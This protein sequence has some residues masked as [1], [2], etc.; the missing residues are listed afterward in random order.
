MKT[1]A[2][3][4][5]G[6]NTFHLLIVSAEGRRFTELYRKREYIILAED[7]IETIGDRAIQR[8]KTAILSFKKS[9]SKFKPEEL[10]IL[11]TAALR[12]ASN[13]DLITDFI[14]EHLLTKPE[15]ISGP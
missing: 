5:L 15:I 8:A 13:G 2:C 9:L 12:R 4:D 11:G 10:R 7:G 14:A 6:T 1:I 3:L